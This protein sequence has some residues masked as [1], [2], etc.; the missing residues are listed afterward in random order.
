[1]GKILQFSKPFKTAKKKNLFEEL[2][3]QEEEELVEFN[4]ICLITETTLQQY[5]L[6]KIGFHKTVYHFMNIRAVLAAVEGRM[7]MGGVQKKGC[8]CCGKIF[9]KEWLVG[10]NW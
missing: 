8:V 10:D 3:I 4:R 7:P 2:K 1:M 6:C 5:F 9:K